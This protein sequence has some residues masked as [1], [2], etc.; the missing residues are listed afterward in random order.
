MSDLNQRSEDV[1]EQEH[2]SG[3][4]LTFVL[5]SEQYGLPI[6]AISEIIGVIHIT[7]VPNTPVH[8]KGIINLRGKIIPVVSLRVKFGMPEIPYDEKTCIVIVEVA[9]KESTR[10][11]GFIVDSVEE[12]VSFAS[13]AIESTPRYG[14]SVDP[15]IL[16][17]IGK[18]SDGSVVML[19]NTSLLVNADKSDS[20]AGISK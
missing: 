9:D 12:V 19:L 15:R 8:C 11:L 4:Y 2:I 1:S 5:M 13:D 7:P 3:R 6:K 20:Y 14:D 18:T 17:G 16:S 10:H